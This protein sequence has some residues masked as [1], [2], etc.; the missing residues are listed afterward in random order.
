[1]LRITEHA[2]A[3]IVSACRA[4]S[5]PPAGGLRIAPIDG[6]EPDTATRSLFVDFVD[7]AEPSDTRVHQ[8]DAS[9]LLAD[10]VERLLADQVLDIDGG[11]KPPQ[12]VVR[13]A[14]LRP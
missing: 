9:V 11:A 7:D 10:G 1:M 8:G 12:L 4:Q 13:D 5:I 2:A 6:P 3:A 14:T